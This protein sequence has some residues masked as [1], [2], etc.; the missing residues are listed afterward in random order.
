MRA[1]LTLTTPAFAILMACGGAPPTAP[2][3]PSAP[4]T[5]AE[6]PAAPSGQSASVASPGASACKAYTVGMSPSECPYLAKGCCH[7]ALAAACSATGCAAG[8]C[9]ATETMPA[10]VSCK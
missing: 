4:A 8:N 6:Q 10:K 1:A 5:K 9:T 7:S 2:E 3:P